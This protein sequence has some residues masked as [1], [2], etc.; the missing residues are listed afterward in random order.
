MK[1]CAIVVGIDRWK[2]NTQKFYE[3][4]RKYEP[5][6]RL[7][8]IDNASRDGY[9][10]G[11]L[12]T[13]TIRT[14]KLIGYGSALNLGLLMGVGRT[15]WFLC[16]NN[17]NIVHGPLTPILETLSPHVL[18][19]SAETYDDRND[20]MLRQSAWLVFHRTLYVDIGGFDSALR[21]AFEDLDFEVRALNAGWGLE[22][23]HLP[24]EHTDKHTRFRVP[25]Y[26]KGWEESRDIYSAKHKLEVLTW[27][28]KPI[29]K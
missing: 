17:D 28:R 11:L 29:S 24:V 14:P 8:I 16:F 26:F 20:I 23:V 10:H 6:M 25:D 13:T 21:Y 27:D 12:N 9:P 22:T 3:S 19:G 7:A 5:D 1:A 4:F 18:Y 2:K 15:D